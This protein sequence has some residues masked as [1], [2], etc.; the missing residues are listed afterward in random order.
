M[1][2][3]PESQRL[4][5]HLPSALDDMIARTQADV[6][7]G[8]A[9]SPFKPYPTLFGRTGGESHGGRLKIWHSNPRRTPTAHAGRSPTVTG[10]SSLTS[11]SPMIQPQQ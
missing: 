11:K 1:A 8:G 4:V 10:T 6:L 5:I 3:D 7:G 9:A 2:G